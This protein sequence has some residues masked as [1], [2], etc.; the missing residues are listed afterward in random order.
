MLP[1]IAGIISSLLAN[2]LPKVAQAVVD[3]GVD[4]VEEKTGIKLEP[5]MS[6]EKIEALK[7]EIQKHEEFIITEDNKNT[8]SA[9]DMNAKVQEAPAASTLAKNTAYILDFVIV[10]AAV[11]VSW[12]AFFKGVPPENKEIVYMALGSLWTLTGTIINFHRGS[13]RNSQIKDETI[14]KLTR[15]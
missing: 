15:L 7:V 13:S 4:Y 9:R 14:G 6:A 11:I 10:A 2:N 8:D 5:D 3:K 12:L 1:L